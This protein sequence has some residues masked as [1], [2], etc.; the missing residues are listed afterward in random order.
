[1]TTPYE[2]TVTCQGLPTHQHSSHEMSTFAIYEPEA[3]KA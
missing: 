1:M 2:L 3:V